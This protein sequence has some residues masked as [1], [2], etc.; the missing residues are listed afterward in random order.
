[1]RHISGLSRSNPLGWAVLAAAALWAATIVAAPHALH[2]QVSVM[3]TGAA[4]AYVGASFVCHQRPERSF[5]AA[6]RPFPVCA[7]CTGLYLAA[8]FGLAAVVL[9]RFGRRTYGWWRWALVAA[10]VPTLLSVGV[11]QAAGISSNTSRALTAIPLGFMVAAL[12]GS[13]LAGRLLHYKAAD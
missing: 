8:P 7:R 6:G 3:R 5:H 10:A 13:G 11:E 12:V 4:I 2:R 9:G 1:M